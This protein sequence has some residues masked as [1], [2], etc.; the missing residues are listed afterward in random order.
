MDLPLL[1]VVYITT[2]NK[3]IVCINH[4]GLLILP[5]YEPERIYSKEAITSALMRQIQESMRINGKVNLVDAERHRVHEP[6][7]NTLTNL[8]A[9]DNENCEDDDYFE[10]LLHGIDP[11]TTPEEIAMKDDSPFRV[12]VAYDCI[13]CA[14]EP[15][16][17]RTSPYGQWASELFTYQKFEEWD[18]NRKA[19]K[20]QEKKI[21]RMPVEEWN[22]RI[23]LGTI[24]DKISVMATEIAQEWIAMI[25]PPSF[26]R[27]TKKKA[28]GKK[29]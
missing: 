23:S 16:N 24:K 10:G 25:K 7:K 21:V 6:K 18:A 5:R 28:M 19:R 11:R 8:P 12:C 1:F 9:D 17:P 15:K 22:T 14:E 3:E 29:K 4:N 26:P 27:K 20:A 13:P 2:N